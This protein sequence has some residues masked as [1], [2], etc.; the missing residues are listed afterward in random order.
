M[1]FIGFF[2]EKPKTQ[3]AE[4]EK[5]GFSQPCS[6]VD[7]HLSSHRIFPCAMRWEKKFGFTSLHIRCCH[8]EYQLVSNIISTPCSIGADLSDAYMYKRSVFGRQNA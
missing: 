6:E 3:S 7:S 2:N 8:N 4:L 1:G 5:L